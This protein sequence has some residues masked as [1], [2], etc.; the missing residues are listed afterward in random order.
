MIGGI[1]WLRA[2]LVFISEMLAGMAAAGV[3]SGLFPG[4][5]AVSTTLNPT[6]SLARG[7]CK[8]SMSLKTWLVGAHKI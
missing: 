6:T 8:L 1:T 3:V 4:P 2:G 5:M 7:L